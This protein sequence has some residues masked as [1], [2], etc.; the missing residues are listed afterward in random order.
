MVIRTQKEFTPTFAQLLSLCANSKSRVPALVGFKLN[1][2]GKEMTPVGAKSGQQVSNFQLGNFN[3]VTYADVAY[4]LLSNNINLV[5]YS[6]GLTEEVV[7]NLT[8]YTKTLTFDGKNKTSLIIPNTDGI[9][10]LSHPY[11]LTT[12]EYAELSMLFLPRNKIRELPPEFR[13]FRV[14]ANEWL[15]LASSYSSIGQVT[16]QSLDEQ[17]DEVEVRFEDDRLE[18]FFRSDL[19]D[20]LKNL[21]VYINEKTREDSERQDEQQ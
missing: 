2:D 1:I 4:Y 3:Q 5:D 21:E 13:Y 14:Y 12:F 15:T 6:A 17:Q 20:A 7:P 18:P 16:W 10:S 8:F 11:D 9:T 19:K